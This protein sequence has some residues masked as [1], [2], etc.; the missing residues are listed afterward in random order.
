[1]VEVA[2]LLI[3]IGLVAGA[4]GGSGGGSGGGDDD[5]GPLEPILESEGENDN[6]E[7]SRFADVFDAG[8]GEDIVFGRGGND[9][10][11]GGIGTDFVD[12]NAG[13]DT[14]T[15][16][17]GDDE[18][19]GGDGNDTI[20][21]GDDPDFI[22][23][24]PGDDTLNGDGGDDTIEGAGGRDTIDGGTG[25]DFIRGGSGDDVIVGGLGADTLDGDPGA[26]LI[27]GRV[28]SGRTD[29]D[30]GD[31]L[32]G[33]NGADRLILGTADLAYG[34]SEGASADGAG[35]T[36]VSGDWIDGSAPTVADFDPDFDTIE[37]LHDP[38]S[39]APAVEVTT[40]VSG[41]QTFFEIRLGGELVLIVAAGAD[42][43]YALTAGD[44]DVLPD[45]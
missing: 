36:F 11:D 34:E 39:P 43:D 20:S 37:L 32:I 1:M 10:L 22:R 35:D 27:D 33:D 25:G 12:G 28:L 16:G 7:G 26:D 5:G 30:V 44:I 13:N 42:P 4:L 21:G 14:I 15:G 18:L 2:L 9:V 31:T 19:R 23:G 6:Y 3:G 17:P 8:P 38:S 45:A 24:G 40:E 29:T 41:G